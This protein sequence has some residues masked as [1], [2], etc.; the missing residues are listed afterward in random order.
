MIPLYRLLLFWIIMAGCFC[1]LSVSNND[2]SKPP[3]V[4][5]QYGKPIPVGIIQNQE[6]V[7]LSGLAVSRKNSGVMWGLNDSGCKPEI[8]A[9]TLEG[10][11]LGVA[12]IDKAENI[13][14][15]DLALGSCGDDWC[16]YIADIGDNRQQRSL[17][18][19][20]IVPEPQI[21]PKVHFRTM[22][23]KWAKHLL[24]QYPDGNHNSEAFVV[25]PDGKAYV[26][27]KLSNGTA[28][29]YA[30]PEGEDKDVITL[31]RVGSLN[32]QLNGVRENAT[33]ADIHPGGER[34]LVRT[35]NN[36]FEWQLPSGAPFTEIVN[37][38][39]SE[40]PAAIE[41]QGEAIA[42]DPATGEYLH[43]SEAVG[44]YKSI[45]YRIPCTGN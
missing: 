6:I 13:D 45:V 25:H 23:V 35:Y 26:I 24:F 28:G 2:N 7:E 20:Y 41:P 21:D 11:N 17:K 33:A 4:C 32:L 14:W 36:A 1:T 10:D 43:A 39:R 27:T 30:F 37:A 38:P 15:E 5:K 44:L 31:E 18:S 22:T 29:F 40:V 34:L 12:K 42:Y 3:P 9:M 19:V 8:Y 16:L